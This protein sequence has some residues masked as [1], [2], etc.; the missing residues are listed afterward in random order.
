[1]AVPQRCNIDAGREVNILIAFDVAQHEGRVPHVGEPGMD[2]R[3][4]LQRERGPRREHLAR[5]DVEVRRDVEGSVGW[6]RGEQSRRDRRQAGVEGI[7][8]RGR[9]EVEQDAVGV[10]R[11]GE[12]REEILV[13]CTT[14]SRD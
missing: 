1:M 4:E 10:V 9:R 8:V 13:D 3:I 12:C 5:V 6:I 11:V 14:G 2:R 7:R